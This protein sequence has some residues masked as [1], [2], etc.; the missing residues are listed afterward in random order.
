MKFLLDVNMPPQLAASLTRAGHTARHA[1]VEGFPKAS[2]I[3][4]LEI[5]KVE[6]EV[7]LTHDL[8]FGQLL[9]FTGYGFP[10]VV[11]FRIHQIN[12][13]LFENLLFLN[14]NLIEPSLIDGAVVIIEETKIRIKKLPI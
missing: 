1:S 13:E 14:W 2:D 5:A 6:N 12:A 9:A 11:I 7:V 10:S 4:L 3:E 8:D